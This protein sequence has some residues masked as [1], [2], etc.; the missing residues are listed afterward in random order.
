MYKTE[1]EKI[2]L[3]F[4]TKETRWEKESQIYLK[5]LHKLS[6]IIRDNLAPNRKSI[7]IYRS[8]VI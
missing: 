3:Y 8:E 2:V 5:S 7:K 4:R 1:T 6:E